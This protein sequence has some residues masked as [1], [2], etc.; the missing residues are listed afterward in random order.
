MCRFV[1]LQW[2]KRT[3]WYQFSLHFGYDALNVLLAT[4]SLY[5]TIP[6]VLAAV[7]PGGATAHSLYFSSITFIEGV[8]RTLVVAALDLAYR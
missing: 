1:S 8:G 4:I 5:F 7:L 2:S 3:G 6:P